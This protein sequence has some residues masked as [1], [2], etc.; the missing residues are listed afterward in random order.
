MIQLNKNTTLRQ[1]WKML[2]LICPKSVLKKV[3]GKNTETWEYYSIYHAL[4]SLGFQKISEQ[5]LEKAPQSFEIERKE[6]REKGIN[7]INLEEIDY[8][9]SLITDK[10]KSP[11]LKE[12]F[13]ASA[14]YHNKERRLYLQSKKQSK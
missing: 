1:E 11:S 8:I 5:M 7:T 14:E 2:K 3:K 13:E 10:I 12:M 4:Y 6:Q 9:C